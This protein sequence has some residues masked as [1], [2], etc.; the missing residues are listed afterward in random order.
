MEK[1]PSVTA[2]D[3]RRWRPM[4][5]VPAPGTDGSVTVLAFDRPVG[6]ARPF[7]RREW[8]VD[9]AGLVSLCRALLDDDAPAVARFDHDR[10]AVPADTVDLMV[11][12]HGRRDACCGSLGAAMHQE[13]EGLL[14][15]TPDASTRLW[16]C[17]HTGGHRFA[18]TALTFPDGY[19]WAHLT[20][21]LAQRLAGRTG[22]P[23]DF[24]AHCRGTSLL[25]GGPAQAAD[26]AALVATGWDWTG[27]RRTARVVAYERD[28]LATTVRI[29]GALADGREVALEVRVE[30]DRHI[31]MPTCGVVAGPE[32]V[33]EPVW[34]VASVT[35][36]ATGPAQ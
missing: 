18:P 1:A 35:D 25:D 17:S 31:P 10:V 15:A 24:A 26:R 28:T 12:T 16:R 7:G 8:R 32:Y 13:L 22:P 19:G 29:D 23:S 6:V 2:P 33:V 36:V 9:P 3:G 14:A 11:C 21:E 5:L 4:G 27:A 34:R 30:V 20:A